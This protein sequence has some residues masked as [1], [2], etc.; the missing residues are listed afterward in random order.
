MQH[1]LDGACTGLKLLA[2]NMTAYD[3]ILVSDTDV[4]FKELPLR[5][6]RTQWA[7]GEYFV[8]EREPYL[9][10]PSLRP[11]AGLNSHLMLIQ[12][13]AQVFRL[14]VDMGR[15]RSFVPY[16]NGEQ[17]VIETVFSPHRPMPAL[18]AHRH[19]KKA[20]LQR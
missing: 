10:W 2:W 20:C 12:P 17:D 4:C 18:P 19:S 6:M 3:H 8:A 15:F 7:R 9:Q 13:D 1:R 11:Y 5:W 16:T 14:L